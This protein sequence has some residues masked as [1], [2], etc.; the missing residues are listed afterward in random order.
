MR[1]TGADSTVRT[2]S[3]EAESR[4]FV[5]PGETVAVFARSDR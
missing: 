5:V 3:Y 2:S 4:T 1:A